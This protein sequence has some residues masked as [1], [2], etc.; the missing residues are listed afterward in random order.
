MADLPIL[1][2][3]GTKR[4]SATSVDYMELPGARKDND[5]VKVEVPGGVSTQLGF[6]ND[7][8]WEEGTPKQF[9]CGTCEYLL[10]YARAHTQAHSGD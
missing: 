6:C 3:G 7:F 8:E 10:S 2:Q 4:K 1:L 9:R 5:C